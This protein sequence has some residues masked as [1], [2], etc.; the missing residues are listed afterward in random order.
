[1]PFELVF[2]ADPGY[3]VTLNSFD[4]AGWDGGDYQ[5]Q[6]AI[7]D[8]NGSLASPNL[9]SADLLVPG[10]NTISPL[11]SPLMASGALHLYISNI[12]STG[13]DNINFDQ[14]PAAS[15]P[16]TV[17]LPGTLWLFGCALFGLHGTKKRG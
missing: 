13:I 17:P 15:P 6:F 16:T 2:T 8:D 7:F 3:Q 14:T 12:G 1:M 11:T 5:T 9:F 4:I 10:A